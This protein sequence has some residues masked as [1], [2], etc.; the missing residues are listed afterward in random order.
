MGT[1]IRVLFQ[2]ISQWESFLKHSVADGH[3]R[4]FSLPGESNCSNCVNQNAFKEDVNPEGSKR[5]IKRSWNLIPNWLA[6]KRDWNCI[7]RERRSRISRG[8]IRKYGTIENLLFSTR[9][10]VE[11]KEEMGQFN[12]LLKMLL[13]VRIEYNALLENKFRVKDDEW[14]D[15]IDN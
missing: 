8:L 13:S 2:E 4:I 1:R 7:L 10:I 11:V 3:R 6:Y 12:D 5:R 9:N 15:E 14:F